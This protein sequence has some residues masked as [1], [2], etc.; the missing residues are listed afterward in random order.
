MVMMMMMV[1]RPPKQS[2]LRPI[3]LTHAIPGRVTRDPLYASPYVADRRILDP[4]KS[5]V[6][7]ELTA[8]TITHDII[9]D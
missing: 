8:L 2:E 6:S 7:A 5:R 9:F 1:G 3:R 4:Q